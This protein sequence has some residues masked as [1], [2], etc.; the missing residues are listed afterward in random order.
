MGGDQSNK[1]SNKQ[2]VEF[3]TLSL[4][5]LK[6]FRSTFPVGLDPDRFELQL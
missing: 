1:Q 2:S 5:E 3:Y 6:R 4:E